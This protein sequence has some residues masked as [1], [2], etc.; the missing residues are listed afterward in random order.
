[1]KTGLLTIAFKSALNRKT[2][3]VLAIVS[4][5]LSITLILSV[6]TVRKQT[7]ERFL[8]TVSQTDLIVGARSGPINLLLYSVFHIGNATN[9]MRYSSYQAIQ[10]FKEVEWAVPLSL[11]DS[12]KGFRVIGTEPTF[13]K[14]LRYGNAQSLTFNQGAPFND[15]YD[16]VIGANVAKKLNYQL[17]QKM[18]LS[19]GTSEIGSPKHGNKPFVVTGILAPTGTPIDNSVQVSLQAIEA[20]HI[21]WQ[22]GMQ[23]PL[24]IT[25]QQTRKIKLQP[26]EITAIMIGLKKPIYTFKMQRTLNQWQSEPLLAIL[27]GATLAQLWQSISL[28]EKVLLAIAA[29]VFVSALFGMLITLLSTLN[30]RR[31]EVAVLRAIGMHSWDI[32]KLF[33]IETALIMTFAIGLGVLSLYGLLAMILPILANTYG[34]HLSLPVLD[35]QQILLLAAAFGIALLLSLLPGWLAYRQ[36]LADGLTVK[37]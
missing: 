27:P 20:I 7:K 8:N 2:N 33:A 19:H 12:H 26:K 21:D 22:G 15:L 10:H 29:M 3:L 28:F 9:N 36:S 30:E 31:R 14:H 34:L 6:D 24:K 16:A 11:G 17:G 18:V 32:I 1:M 35:S 23:S 5:A 13:Y 4:I 37:I 25:A